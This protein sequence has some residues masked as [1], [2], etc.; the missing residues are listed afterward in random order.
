MKYDED[1]IRERIQK[2]I[3]L[4]NLTQREFANKLGRQP[5]NISQILNN[6]RGVPRGLIGD[7]LAAFPKLQKE[8]LVFG[9]GKMYEGNDNEIIEF[10]LNTRPRLPK[11]EAGGHLEDYFNGSKRALCQEKQIISQF[12]DY[13]FS[14][15]L[16]NSRM[17][18]KYNQGDELF[19]KKSTIIEWGNDYLLDTAE[20]AKFKRIYD[21][22]NKVRCVSYNKEEYPEF[23][24]PK[25]L[26]FGYYRL[27]GM[28][29]IL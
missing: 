12:S 1:R 8:W 2:L 10:P 22:G 9:D 14:I 18:P 28:I 19:F 5:S 16:K 26:I 23:E 25:E 4:E 15:I 11:N 29:R 24:V 3:H 13:D 6:E 21:E 7:I 20:G 27:V 17:S